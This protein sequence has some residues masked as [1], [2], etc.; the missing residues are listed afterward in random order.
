MAVPRTLYQHTPFNMLH[1]YHFNIG[2]VLAELHQQLNWNT[3]P[4]EHLGHSALQGLCRGL[5]QIGLLQ[6]R[7][8]FLHVIWDLHHSHLLSIFPPP[9]TLLEH[10]QEI[11][12]HLLPLLDTYPEDVPNALNHI[13]D[14]YYIRCPEDFQQEFSFEALTR[15]VISQAHLACI[16]IL[17][18]HRHEDHKL[19]PGLEKF[20]R[21]MLEIFLGN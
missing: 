5:V 18:T 6:L 20:E 8:D 10:M 14:M 21:E 7:S 13:R 3:I 1:V 15:F 16:S 11:H 4:P 9:F 12:N 2:E 17:P 19:A